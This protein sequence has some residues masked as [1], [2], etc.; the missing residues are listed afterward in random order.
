MVLL[1]RKSTLDILYS[2]T[3][4]I[5]RKFKKC[6]FH[7]PPGEHP[8]DPLRLWCSLPAP[9]SHGSLPSHLGSDILQQATVHV[10]FHLIVLRLWY[11]TLGSRGSSYILLVSYL[12]L[13]H[14][15]T[16][17]LYW[18]GRNGAVRKE[19]EEEL[20]IWFCCIYCTKVCGFANLVSL[21]V[22]KN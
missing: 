18:S 13:S 6:T 22:F 12:A 9:T 11:P 17:K 14:P 4:K 19:E 8:P 7:V 16:L 15:M 21:R 1:Y 2:L 5:K 20:C 10:D 3:D